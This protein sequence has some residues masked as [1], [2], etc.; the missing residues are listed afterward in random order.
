MPRTTRSLPQSPSTEPRRRSTRI[1]A[2]PQT[3]PEPKPKPA[4]KK[5]PTSA[6]KPERRGRPAGS[7]KKT[8]SPKKSTR[9]RKRKAQPEPAEDEEPEAK[10]SKDETEEEP[11][12]TEQEDVKADGAGDGEKEGGDATDAQEGT[13]EENRKPEVA[14]SQ[15]EKMETNQAK[16][17]A[18]EAKSEAPPKVKPTIPMMQNPVVKITASQVPQHSTVAQ[19]VK[20]PAATPAAPPTAPPTALPQVIKASPPAPT[21]AKPTVTQSPAKQTVESAPKPTAALETSQAIPE[22]S[23]AAGPPAP[24]RTEVQPTAQAPVTVSTPIVIPVAD[25]KSQQQQ[26]DVVVVSANVQN[27]T[28]AVAE[29]A[30]APE[31]TRK[32]EDVAVNLSQDSSKPQQETAAPQTDGGQGAVSVADKPVEEPSKEQDVPNN[33]TPSE[34]IDNLKKDAVQHDGM[35]NG[36]SVAPAAAAVAV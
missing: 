17:P 7:A 1:A 6:E 24:S 26:P 19:E 31:T 2:L 23:Q 36:E 16:A 33:A 13:D 25:T 9:G 21:A 15:D 27:V 34:N 3:S 10:T 35:N 28:A 32:V 11:A 4:P 29:K 18:P 30:A 12:E 5:T 8:P 22:T 14:E 20:K